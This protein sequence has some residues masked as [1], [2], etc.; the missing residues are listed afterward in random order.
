MVLNGEPA[1][2]RQSGQRFHVRWH[3]A[4]VVLHERLCHPDQR[5]GL[6]AEKAGRMD[7]RLEFL[8]R[9]LRQCGSGRITLEQRRRDHV[10]ALIGR[11]RRQDRRDQQLKGVGVVQLG[12]GIRV[13]GLQPVEEVPRLGGAFHCGPP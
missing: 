6:G 13:L 11:L 1:H 5:F 2:A 4:C 10:D 9:R 8:L 3:F 7:L 12:V